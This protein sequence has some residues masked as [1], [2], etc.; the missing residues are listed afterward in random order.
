MPPEAKK[1][2]T[3]IRDAADSVAEF[4]A[5]KTLADFSSDK[6]LCSGIYYQFAII[7]EALAQLRAFDE[8]IAQRI[9]EQWRII[10]F[11]NQ[12]IHGY[13]KIDHEITWGIIAGKLP[14]LQREVN[15]LLAE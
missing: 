1:L 10:G 14:I 9:S 3:D 7:G 15:E 13:A 5:G 2:L 6:L 11:R 8:T 4:A 12:I